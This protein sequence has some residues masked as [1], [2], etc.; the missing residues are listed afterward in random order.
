MRGRQ[1][2]SKEGRRKE[3][4]KRG[5][6]A[7]KREKETET[8]RE[9]LQSLLHS[10]VFLCVFLLFC[11]VFCSFFF[12]VDVPA[13]GTNLD[14]GA[15]SPIQGSH[16][17]GRNPISFDSLLLSLRSALSGSWNEKPKLVVEK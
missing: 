2:G 17:G 8:W 10:V 15:G 13:L 9:K 5:A 14:L 11:F 3:T 4:W 1:R 7:G 6:G 12:P 16:G